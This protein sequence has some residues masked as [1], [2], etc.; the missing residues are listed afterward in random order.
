MTRAEV[1]RLAVYAVIAFM[2]VGMIIKQSASCHDAG[3]TL[4]RGLVWLECIQ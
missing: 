3:G 2:S 1:L 4:V